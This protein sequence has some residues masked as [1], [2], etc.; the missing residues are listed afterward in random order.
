MKKTDANTLF[1]IYKLQNELERN[2]YPEDLINRQILSKRSGQRRVRE[3]L[4]AGFLQEINEQGANVYNLS[5]KG[6]DGMCAYRDIRI[7][8]EH[9][10]EEQEEFVLE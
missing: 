7:E 2:V 6:I 9:Y 8:Y 10:N 4:E 3:L 1:E 5:L